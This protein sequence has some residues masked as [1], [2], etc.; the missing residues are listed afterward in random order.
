MGI[1]AA[2]R[3]VRVEKCSELN[4]DKWISTWER[5]QLE[6]KKRRRET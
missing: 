3:P 4:Q 5:G 2:E 6:S 1:E